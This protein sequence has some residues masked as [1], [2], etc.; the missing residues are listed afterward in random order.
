MR[1]VPVRRVQQAI[2]RAEPAFLADSCLCVCWFWVLVWKLL[3]THSMFR[4]ILMTFVLMCRILCYSIPNLKFVGKDND[5]KEYC[6][7]SN[8]YINIYQDANFGLTLVIGY[9]PSLLFIWFYLLNILE[10]TKMI[11][12][13]KAMALNMAYF[14]NIVLFH[15]LI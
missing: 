13:S 14:K 11:T 4:T 1:L 6:I 15:L 2:G 7:F 9:R 12:N 10:Y 3:S 8:K 5:V